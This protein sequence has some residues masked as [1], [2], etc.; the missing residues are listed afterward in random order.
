MANLDGIYK[1]LLGWPILGMTVHEVDYDS[2][3]DIIAQ[4]AER[5]ESSVICAANVHM[6]MEAFDDP[7]F[8]RIINSADLVT[9]DGMPLKW[10]INLLGGKLLD[11]VYGPTLALRICERAAAKS[12]PVGFYGGT[13]DSLTAL[14]QALQLKFPLL[15][16]DYAHSPPFRTLTVE[17][18]TK[19]VHL[20]G[21]SGIRILFVGLG[22]PK[23]ERWMHLHR[24]SVPL[25]MVGVGAFFD[26][27]SGRIRQAPA[28]MQRCG[29][30]WLFRLLME[31]RRLFKRYAYNNP[32]FVF[33][34]LIQLLRFRS[35]S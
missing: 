7:V 27:Y 32:R 21:S 14:T 29:L 31:P 6:V 13:P 22:C 15:R 4:C 2:S 10:L 18:D 33:L 9:P 35:F 17:E 20:I 8:K 11:R 34:A 25:V 23:Q 30:E 5:T 28:W 12:I 24:E 19:A 1:P 16:I 26:F 3:V